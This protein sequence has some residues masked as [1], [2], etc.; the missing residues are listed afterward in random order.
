MPELYGAI[1]AG[2]GAALETL[3]LENPI[4]DSLSISE[5]AKTDMAKRIKREITINGAKRWV[6]GANE[7]EYAEKLVQLMQ[8]QTTTIQHVAVE[9]KHRF[10]DYAYKWFETFSKPN[11][12]KVTAITYERQLRLH[13]CPVLG[14]MSVED[15]KPFDVQSVFNR[16]GDTAKET[17]Q[18]VKIVLNMIFEQ[19]VEDELLRRNPLE[20][21]SI[22][23]TGTSSQATEPY[24]VEQMQYLVHHIDQIQKPQD[25]AYLALHALHPLRLEEVLGLKGADVEGRIM[26]VRRAVTHP[27]R[28]RPIVKETKTSVSVRDLD[29]VEQIKKYLPETAPDEFI[30]GGKN[31]LSYTQVRKM[32]ERIRRDTE[33]DEKITPIRFRTTVLTDMYDQTKDLKQ[34]QQAAGHANAATTMKHYVKG[35]AEH[36][37]TAIPVAAAYGLQTDTRADTTRSEKSQMTAGKNKGKNRSELTRKLTKPQKSSTR[38]ISGKEDFMNHCWRR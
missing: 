23:I 14:E 22:R 36:S 13:I 1:A 12:E 3:N 4:A 7:Q 16:M 38:P 21:K 17:K 33:F 8:E 5:G 30:L 9:E 2:I 6:T 34:T 37:N 35:R 24:S 18:K 26:H 29:L 15:I 25:R 19:A 27:D 28:N 20:S 11:V 32:C 10:E 31:P